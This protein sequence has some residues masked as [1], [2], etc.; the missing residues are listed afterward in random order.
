MKKQ[1]G[2]KLQLNKKTVTTLTPHEAGGIAGGAGT[3]NLITLNAIC[4]VKSNNS[5]VHT[6]CRTHQVITGQ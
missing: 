1:F 6:I 4:E 3:T 5:R 2:R